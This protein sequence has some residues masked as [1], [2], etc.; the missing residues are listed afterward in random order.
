MQYNV[1]SLLL[2]ARQY[3]E[4][5][6]ESYEYDAQ[7]RYWSMDI[8]MRY[9]AEST[10]AYDYLQSACTMVDADINAVLAVARSIRTQEK[11]LSYWAQVETTEREEESLK[12]LISK[13]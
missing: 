3:L 2:M 9:L 8:S 1:K 11:K 6:R 5:T 4:T 10:T 12:R 13:R 7:K